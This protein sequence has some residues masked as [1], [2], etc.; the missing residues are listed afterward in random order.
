MNKIYRQFFLPE[1]RKPKSGGPLGMGWMGFMAPELVQLAYALFTAI[2]IFF[3]WTNLEAPQQLMWQRLTY[4]SGIIALWVVYK[5]WPCRFVLMLRFLYLLYTLAYWYPDTYE[6]NHQFGCLDHLFAN[7][8][9]DMFGMQPS[10]R[11]SEIFSSPVVSELMYFGYLSYYLFFVVT[12]FYVFFKHYDQVERVAYIIMAGFFICYVIFLFL[13]VVGPQY[14]Y[15][16]AGVEEIAHGTFPDVGNYFREHTEAIT[17][18]GWNG[19]IFYHLCELAHQTGERPT[20][21]FPSSHVAIATLVMVMLLR[22]RLWKN[23]LVLAIPYVFL[24]LSTV[25]IMAHYAIDAIA[26]LFFGII[27][28]FIL[29]GM[30]L[31]KLK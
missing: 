30:K 26:G 7:Y 15:L 3:T 27:L 4:V 19:G 18:P 21:A 20:A 29:G 10:L 13:P 2:V 22:M 6:I 25:Y 12:I 11:F 9:Q 24:C 28:F 14:Y 16:A 1:K 8:E 23:L 5:L 31:S 17:M